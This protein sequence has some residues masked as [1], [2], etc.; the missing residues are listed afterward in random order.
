MELYFVKFCSILLVCMFVHFAEISSPYSSYSPTVRYKM[1]KNP[2]T[3]TNMHT[4][5]G[6]YRETQKRGGANIEKNQL[7][8]VKALIKCPKRGAGKWPS[9]LDGAPVWVWWGAEVSNSASP[10][11]YAYAHINTC[12]IYLIVPLLHTTKLFLK[13]IEWF[14]VFFYLWLL[15]KQQYVCLSNKTVI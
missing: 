6:A 7:F 11:L 15:I 9:P 4:Y 3:I 14:V 1:F 2:W 5:T 10:P 8:F 12:Y 13:S